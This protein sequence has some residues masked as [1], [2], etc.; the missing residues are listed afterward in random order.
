MASQDF[1][2]TN[3]GTETVAKCKHCNSEMDASEAEGHQCPTLAT[4]SSPEAEIGTPR[5]TTATSAS[6]VDAPPD[7]QK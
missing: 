6:S 5:T 4:Y 2:Y 7:D 1:E 3:K